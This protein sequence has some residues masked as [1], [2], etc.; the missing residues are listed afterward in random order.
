MTAA[1]VSTLVGFLL[2]WMA[3]ALP[4]AAQD[5]AVDLE[6][7]LAVDVSGSM[8]TD[9]QALQR[10][11][12]IEALRSKDV[13]DA[14]RTGLHGRIAVTY[15]EWAGPASQRVVVPWTVLDGPLA[16]ESFA[17]TLAAAPLGT[18]RG[19]SISG[20]LATAAALFSGNGFNGYRRVIDISGDGPNNMGDPVLDTRDAVL[21][22]GI[23]INGLPIML[24]PGARGYGTIDDLDD[25][26][27]NCVIGGAGAFLVP[28]ND[29]AQWVEA[30]RRKMI[31]EI[32]DTSDGTAYLAEPIADTG[33]DCL[34]GEKQRRM[35][36]DP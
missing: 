6:L 12:Y 13:M 31:L 30:I 20:G 16:A 4:A 2:S 23:I 35:W 22:L 27:A 29:R 32:A 19:T 1:K 8:D 11:G 5:Q 9:E 18:M 36:V 14:I 33:Y 17:A 28:V 34:V 21:S 24:K 26:Y 25:Y 7:V 3:A 10:S 15:L